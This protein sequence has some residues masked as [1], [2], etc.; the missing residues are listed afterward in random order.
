MN[1]FNVEKNTF[2]EFNFCVTHIQ[3]Y[4]LIFISKRANFNNLTIKK[5]QETQT[6]SFVNIG[7]LD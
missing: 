5:L 2:A 6:K 7:L 1:T 4:L 3:L